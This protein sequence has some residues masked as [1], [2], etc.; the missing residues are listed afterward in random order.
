VL[1]LT[2]DICYVFLYREGSV[3]RKQARTS[4][5]EE[6]RNV[7]DRPHVLCLVEL[8]RKIRVIAYLFV[9]LNKMLK[10]WLENHR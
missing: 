5:K 4:A 10:V 8:N 9:S 7:Q 1:D 3:V 2:G 6:T